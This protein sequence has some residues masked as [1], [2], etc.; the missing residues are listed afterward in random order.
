MSVN[1]AG[2]ELFRQGLDSKFRIAILTLVS[3]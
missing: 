1:I 3:H 2:V